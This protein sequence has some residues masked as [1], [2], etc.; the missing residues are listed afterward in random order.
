MPKVRIVERDLTTNV[1]LSEEENIFLIPDSGAE[2]ETINIYSYGDK[3][4]TGLKKTEIINKILYLGGKVC[5]IKT[6]TDTKVRN[7]LKDRNQFNIKFILLVQAI[8]DGGE[9][10]TSTVLPVS[11]IEED[12]GATDLV[13][14]IDI[15]QRRR[16]VSIIYTK[17]STT[18]SEAEQTLLKT[19]V[20]GDEFLKTE[21]K[22]YLGKYVLPYYANTLSTTNNVIV[23]AG[24][25]YAYAYLNNIQNNI[26]PYVSVAGY[27]QG[28]IPLPDL[29]CEYL[30]ED[31]IDSMQ[32]DVAPEEGSA[33]SINTVVNLKCLGANSIRILGDRTALPLPTA[34]GD[35][36]VVV[37][38]FASNRILLND[39]K[40]RMYAASRRFQYETIND[41]LIANFKAYV[42][43]KLDVMKASGRLNWYKWDNVATSDKTK[44]F[45]QLTV[46]IGY[47]FEKAD[48]LIDISD[49][50]VISE[51]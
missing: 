36:G 16:D 25:A 18:Y 14:A 22:S 15:V 13:C 39:I 46:S 30:T 47:P 2:D 1:S 4:P 20:E 27:K 41:V 17:L 5:V 21:K 38:S 7:Y 12:T 50:L 40:K 34:E 24:T 31:E 6:L 43:E 26:S 44:V 28:V 9:D 42:E 10:Q 3:L 29:S 45:L 11:K 33:I 51:N 32:P 37:S 8:S 35:T 48:M 23:N 19:L 49:D